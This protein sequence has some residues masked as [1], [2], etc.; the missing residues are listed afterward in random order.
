MTDTPSEPKHTPETFAA[1]LRSQLAR[2]GYPERGGQREFAKH[3]GIS[4]A[5]VS[6]LLRAD[7]LP[8]VR[9][10]QALSEAL[11]IPLGE[12]LVRAGVA[13]REDLAAAA[14]PVTPEPISPEQAAAELGITSPEAVAAFV[15]M[16]TALRPQEGNQ[17][18]NSS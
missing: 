16:V 2:R 9:T 12:L 18:T 4:T 13:S 7:G 11:R 3:S 17:R 1:W 5:T 6:R 14:R 8:D 10:L 15:A